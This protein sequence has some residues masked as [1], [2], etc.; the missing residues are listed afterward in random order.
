MGCEQSDLRQ[1]PQVQPLP[2]VQP[3]PPPQLPQQAVPP[4]QQ[5]S[6]LADLV[7]HTPGLPPVPPRCWYASPF[8]DA[9]TAPLTEF[10]YQSKG[11]VMFA[12]RPIP[13]CASDLERL[14]QHRPATQDVF[15][16]RRDLLYGMAYLHNTALFTEHRWRSR[17]GH[18]Q[19][20][21]DGTAT[22][23]EAVRKAKKYRAS[24]Q[25]SAGGTSTTS[26]PITRQESGPVSG[27]LCLERPESTIFQ[28]PSYDTLIGIRLYLD[29]ELVPDH[30]P[31]PRALPQ[32]TATIDA[33]EAFL[34]WVAIPL[35]LVGFLNHDSLNPI[36]LYRGLSLSFVEHLLH[37]KTPV[38]TAAGVGKRPEAAEPPTPAPFR[39]AELRVEIVY[40]CRSEAYFCTDFIARGKCTLLLSEEAK[41]PLKAYEERLRTLMRTKRCGEQICPALSDGPPPRGC[42]YC[43]FPL[44]YRC[45]VCGAEFCGTLACAQRSLVGYPRGCSEHQAQHN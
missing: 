30:Y 3:P 31:R 17:V 22:I 32:C 44:A 11:R 10:H 40:G 35:V 28:K 42:L 26:D 12:K 21:K 13:T 2:Q 45:T 15:D 41:A 43:G 6:I 1:A 18:L 39:K 27:T 38:V 5:P 25:L 19:R 23:P 33:H 16:L 29:G 20:V 14:P 24:R 8:V 9:T 37:L 7:Q 36:E 4:Q 34:N